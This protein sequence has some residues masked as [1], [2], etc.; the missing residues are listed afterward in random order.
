[1]SDRRLAFVGFDLG[2]KSNYY[3][4]VEG[5]LDSEDDR[6][7]RRG[8][9]LAEE[10]VELW[11]EDHSCPNDDDEYWNDLYA[12]TCLDMWQSLV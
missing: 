9:R 12:E 5:L 3:D 1:M 10:Q 11:E 4:Y 7:V 6:K 2:E 8:Q